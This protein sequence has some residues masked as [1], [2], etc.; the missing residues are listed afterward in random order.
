MR[1]SAAYLLFTLAPLNFTFKTPRQRTLAA[2]TVAPHAGC[3]RGRLFFYLP[4]WI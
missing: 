2:V 3:Q 4:S 1:Q